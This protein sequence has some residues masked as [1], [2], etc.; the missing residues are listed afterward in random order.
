[1]THGRLW[2][3]AEVDLLKSIWHTIHNEAAAL[4]VGR[5]LD[6]CEIKVRRLYAVDR[7][8]RKIMAEREPA[9]RAMVHDQH[10]SFMLACSGR[11]EHYIRMGRRA[12]MASRNDSRA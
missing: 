1:M 8:F 7:S 5:S 6:A 11:P 10:T 12:I 9:Y 3:A 2:T 4:R